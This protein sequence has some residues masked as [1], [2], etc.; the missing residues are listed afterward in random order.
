MSL[1]TKQ[2]KFT[3]MVALFILHAQ[4]LGYQITGSDWYRAE[5]INYGLSN[6]LHKKRLAWDFNLFKDGKF[7]KTT[8]EYQVMGEYWE[9]IG[10]TWGGRFND[11]NHISLEHEGVK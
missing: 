3:G 4:Q 10:G 6:S 5:S 7:L 11:G 9:S 1:V 8:E 2:D